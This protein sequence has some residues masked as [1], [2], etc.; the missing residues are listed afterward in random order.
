MGLNGRFRVY[1]YQV[2]DHFKIHGDGSWPG[3]RVRNINNGTLLTTN[4]FEEEG[5]WSQYSFLISLNED[6]QGGETEFWADGFNYS[7]PAPTLS[8]GI[9]VPV[10]TPRGGVLVFPHGDHPLHCLHA[11]TPITSGVKYII[12]TDVLFGSSDGGGTTL[13]DTKLSDT[14]EEDFS[15]SEL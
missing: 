9:S 11:S 14:M 7:Q 10:R 12:R 15:D 6:Y 2:G 8:Q 1:K 5:W 4:A 3:S 13:P